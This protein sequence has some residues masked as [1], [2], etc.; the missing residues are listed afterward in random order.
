MAAIKNRYEFVYYVACTNGNPNGDPDMGNAPRLDPETMQGYIT[1]VATKRR[2]RNYVQVA[3]GDEPG[4]NIIIQQG[5]NINRHIAEA[6]QAAGV[7]GA[8]DKNAVYA[9]RKKA[10]ELFYDVRTFGAVMST[11]PNAGQVR[12][13]VQ[14]TFG[15]SLD[16]VVPMD[17]SITRMAAALGD[18]DK[19]VAEYMDIE[20]KSDEDALRTMGRKQLIPFGLYEVRGFIS[21]NLAAET[22]FDDRDLE[23]LFEAILNMYEHDRSASKGEMAVVS[24]LILF[25]H[26]GTDT[27]ERQREKQA[28]LG[29]A[30][31]HRLFDLVKVEK[32]AEVRAPRSYR[33]YQAAVALER[34][35]DGV[36]IGFKADAF[37]PVVW[38]TLPETEDW[39]V[40][41]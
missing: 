9:G 40:N 22:G 17:I 13:P 32:K 7:E 28:R 1:D 30:P 38:D 24:P 25:K 12:G 27:D 18:K 21:A 37:S 2:I 8:K 15:K 14:I 41:G 23:I 39:F 5:T 29:C 31:A 11:G 10:C 34:V 16:P 35:P 26:V 20:E 19:T 33:D 3:H 4:M 36:R 6:R